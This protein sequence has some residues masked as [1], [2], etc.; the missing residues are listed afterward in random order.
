[1]SEKHK[2]LLKKLH[3]WRSSNMKQLTTSSQFF[4]Y[5]SLKLVLVPD[6]MN[7]KLHNFQKCD[8]IKI[9][10]SILKIKRHFLKEKNFFH[11]EKFS[12][13]IIKKYCTHISQWGRKSKCWNFKKHFGNAIPHIRL[14]PHTNT[15][16]RGILSHNPKPKILSPLSTSLVLYFSSHFFTEN[17]DG[18]VKYPSRREAPENFRIIMYSDI[19]AI[20]AFF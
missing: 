17:T 13:L 3:L 5:D 12:I 15:L 1:M 14:P 4:S 6:F 7:K 9:F 19:H 8:V 16:F 20:A 18:L 11:F 2:P 10:E